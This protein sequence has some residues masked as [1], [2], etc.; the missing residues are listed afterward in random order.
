MPDRRYHLTAI[1]L[2]ILY[3]NDGNHDRD[4]LMFLPSEYLPLHDFIR[5][6]WERD[7]YA[8]RRCHDRQRRIEQ[9]LDA[10]DRRSLMLERCSASEQRT[11][12]RYRG[13]PHH[14]VPPEE[15]E[16]RNP[17]GAIAQPARRERARRRQ[18]FD[19]CVDEI[20]M[21]LEELRQRS[22]A[23]PINQKGWTALA[24][25]LRSELDQVRQARLVW[26]EQQCLDLAE[27]EAKV[28]KA[29]A[30]QGI[31]DH[32]HTADDIARLLLNGWAPDAPQSGRYTVFDPMR[33]CPLVEPLVV[34]ACLGESVEIH[35]ENKIQPREGRWSH[36]GLHV[37][38]DGIAVRTDDG[39]W[40][41]TNPDSR[42]ASGEQRVYHVE[43]TH[44]GTYIINDLANLQSG[45]DGTNV[46]GLF[47][48]F[49]VE[50]KG[51]H[52]RNPQ[53]G[54]PA[55]YGLYV[56]VLRD[57]APAAARAGR[58]RF[59]D[60]FLDDERWPFREYTVFIHD[61]PETHSPFPHH[62]AEPAVMPISYRAE[63][64][65][66]RLPIRLRRRLAEQPD[67]PEHGP[68]PLERSRVA[69][70]ID[71]SFDE[72]FTVGSG[73]FEERVAGE[74]QHHSSWLFGEPATPV[75]RAYA[76]DPV[77]IRL[78]H[79][80]IKEH[81]VFHLHVHQW[82][83][84]PQD[85]AAPGAGK[86]SQLVDSI[87]IGPQTCFDIDPLY[88]AGSR[89]AAPGDV[90]WHCHLYPHFHHGMWGLMRVHDRLLS[91]DDTRPAPTHTYPDGTPCPALRPLP[92]FDPP[93]ATDATP[94]FPWFID[95]KAGQKSPPPPSLLPEATNGR[96]TNAGLPP[97]SALERAAAALDGAGTHRPG[98]FFVDL[99][100]RCHEWN[101]WARLEDRTVPAQVRHYD[102]VVCAL[103]IDYNR[104][105]WHDKRAHVYLLRAEF[106][107]LRDIRRQRKAAR[108]AAERRKVDRAW[109]EACQDVEP[110]FPRANHGDVVELTLYNRLPRFA[111]D[112]VD[113]PMLPVECGLHVHLVKF[114]V[115]AAD[116]SAT[117]WNYLSGAPSHEA[118]QDQ[119]RLN[120]MTPEERIEHAWLCED[121]CRDRKAGGKPLNV[122]FH[123]WVVDEEFGPCFFHDHLLANYRQKHGLYAALIA[124]P[125][126][127]EWLDP[128][129]PTV[130]GH[131]R[132]TGA[133]AVIRYPDPAK[134]GLPS[135]FR[136][137]CLASADFIPM[138]DRQGR[139]VNPPSELSG[140]D[141]PGVM[142]LNYRC[143]P[144]SG[145]G[146]DPSAWFSSSA[147][148]GGSEPDTPIIH[149]YVNEPLR[150][151]HIQGAHEEQHSFVLHGLRWRQEW[152][153]PKSPLVDQ[154]TT[155]ISEAF[156]F[157]IDRPYGAGDHLYALNAI[158][159]L[160][161]GCWGIVRVHEHQPE[162]LPVA[163]IPTEWYTRVDRR[164][165]RPPEPDR[166]FDVV[167][168]RR[169]IPYDST[170]LSDPYGLVFELRAW[171][172]GGEDWHHV[173]A[174]TDPEPLVLRCRAGEWV[175][176]TLTNELVNDHWPHALEPEP[177][178]VKL[179][180][181]GDRPE[182]TVS[183]RVSLHA[184]LVQHDVRTHAGSWVGDNLDSTVASK[185]PSDDDHPHAATG[186]HHRN[187]ETSRSYWWY[188]D[189]ALGGD[190]GSVC[191]LSDFAD[192]RNHRHHGLVGAL[193]VEPKGA[194][195]TRWYGASTVIKRGDG[196]PTRELVL[197]PQD[198]LRHYVAGNP[199]WPVP[200]VET[201]IDAEDAG[202]KGINLRS[203]P[204]NHAVG[205]QRTPSTPV[206]EAHKGDEL[207]VRL[208]G[209]NDKPRGH[210]F[211]VHGMAWPAAPWLDDGPWAGCVAGI[212]PGFARTL[213]M[214]CHAPGSHVY[215]DGAVRWGIEGGMWGIIE[216][217][218]R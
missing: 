113:L 170:A 66:N 62:G 28:N 158:D 193:V 215:R 20:R 146:D 176:V 53:T 43:A 212:A 161:L 171:R 125:H 83:L 122:S 114:D 196:V 194:T 136:E 120:R 163:P 197:L 208:I 185:R 41:G 76:G 182:R 156:T 152:K 18:N 155:G 204:V 72:W 190:H 92:G 162:G 63:P 2:P 157:D 210:T 191:V 86:G 67:A 141:D 174:P 77:R 121:P 38:G 217:H 11:L 96:R 144:L 74:E 68:D 25:G 23:L 189:E 150:I 169:A 181:E 138:W 22:F 75:L 137:A 177:H 10:I 142:G 98:S 104:G 33:P 44:E 148:G 111:A 192:V 12:S 202:Q 90:I 109:R 100:A 159:D 151:R 6:E 118:F 4:G 187:R 13:R 188:A 35:L 81:H 91:D 99:D 216:V 17:V 15:R 24:S 69:R 183:S 164:K 205:L 105:G 211:T 47:G 198:G 213:V 95:G 5:S 56:D 149:T 128:A 54:R 73:A 134:G 8:A 52:W 26:F 165:T 132:R 49:V 87:T 39:S 214:H 89:Q 115:L 186:D 93:P 168:R 94:G 147:L 206:F 82:R 19:D 14:G 127:A 140:D 70:V 124:E 175:K 184:G 55:R 36:I 84:V 101:G 110:F 131:H 46:H 29:L 199:A 167:A 48:A 107:K 129:D 40:T 42:V 133:T 195:P 45:E 207:W 209:A 103:P 166:E 172:E 102:V 145:R 112:E 50:P 34:R 203:A 119:A 179:P 106:E 180:L 59:V 97:C 16:R 58:D 61:E 88:G 30:D 64:M 71:D 27:L 218:D 21:H 1:E 7:G 117:G 126:G 154:V 200:D 57:Q 108:T 9:I 160:W 60:F 139:P 116:G 78:V 51:T 32:A 31:V 130:G 3:T 178:P 143:S 123:R 80:G 85:T 201:D 135:A 37:Q 65:H 153:N 173:D 79:A